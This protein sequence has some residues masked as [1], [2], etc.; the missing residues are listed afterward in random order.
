AAPQPLRVARAVLASEVERRADDGTAHAQS[1]ARA[2]HRV[3]HGVPIGTGR[4]RKLGIAAGGRNDSDRQE[5]DG[6]AARWRHGA[7]IVQ[8]RGPRVRVSAPEL[9]PFSRPNANVLPV[10]RPW[11]AFYHPQT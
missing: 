7:P 1:I 4:G 8:D 9:L 11:T 3:P 2:E 10:Q 5:K 6:E